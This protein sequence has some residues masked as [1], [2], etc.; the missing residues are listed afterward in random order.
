MISNND[1]IRPRHQMAVPG[2]GVFI[3]PKAI[4]RLFTLTDYSQCVQ[5]LPP[6][7]HSLFD[8]GESPKKVKPTLYP[9]LRPNVLHSP[10]YYH[11]NTR[12][13]Q[14]KKQYRKHSPQQRR[15]YWERLPFSF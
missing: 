7:Q 11:V 8:T 3:A 13:R 5:L 2:I 10:R 4:A 14:R 1:D 6:Q 9:I 15:A 12:A